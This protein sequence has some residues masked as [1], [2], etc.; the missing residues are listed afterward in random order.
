MSFL[1]KM[2]HKGKKKKKTLKSQISKENQLAIN[3]IKHRK[4]IDDHFEVLEFRIFFFLI[5]RRNP[6]GI[7]KKSQIWLF[8]FFSLASGTFWHC[9]LELI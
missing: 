2:S 6:L 9:L 5:Y 7:A 1:E 4:Q 3:K 8:L